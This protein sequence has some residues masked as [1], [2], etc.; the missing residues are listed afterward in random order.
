MI[1]QMLTFNQALEIALGPLEAIRDRAQKDW[2]VLCA[3]WQDVRHGKSER[4]STD[5]EY[6]TAI[7][8]LHVE[9]ERAERSIRAVRNR[10]ALVEQEWNVGTDR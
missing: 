9:V 4:H 10:F 5:I 7:S 8:R 2:K 1:E 6:S 3:E